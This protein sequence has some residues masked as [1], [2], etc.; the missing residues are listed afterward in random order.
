MQTVTK[1]GIE[2]AWWSAIGAQ[3]LRECVR[4]LEW[5]FAAARDQGMQSDLTRRVVD[6]LGGAI[7]CYE[8]ASEE[9]VRWR[10]EHLGTRAPSNPGG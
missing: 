5:L 4:D 9:I 8:T 7:V 10:E 1:D 6:A 2:G 3:R